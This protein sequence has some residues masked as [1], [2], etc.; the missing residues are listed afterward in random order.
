MPLNHQEAD[1]RMLLHLN[2]ASENRHQKAMIRAVDTDVLFFVIS[3]CY[4]LA[5]LELWIYFGTEK[6]ISK[7]TYSSAECI[8][9]SRHKSCIATIPRIYRM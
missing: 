4:D 5:L 3:T 8:F 1:S 9:M 7:Y 6:V 2:R